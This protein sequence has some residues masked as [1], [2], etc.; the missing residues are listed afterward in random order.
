MNISGLRSTI[1]ITALAANAFAV[2]WATLTQDIV[3]QGLSTEKEANPLIEKAQTAG[4]TTEQMADL[5]EP[6]RKAGQ[7]HLPTRPLLDKLEEGLIK[8]VKP[9]SL[10]QAISTRYD[11][12]VQASQLTQIIQPP[13]DKVLYSVT[14]ALE[15]GVPEPVLQSVITESKGQNSGQIQAVVE[16]GETMYLNGLDATS[17]Q[18]LMT[19][20]LQR[21]LRRSEILRTT[22]YACQQHRAG[23]QG[24]AIRQSLWGQN[25]CDG[26]GQRQRARDGSGGGAGGEVGKEETARKRVSMNRGQARDNPINKVVTV[27]R[28]ETEDKAAREDRDN[29][30]LHPCADFPDTGF[31]DGLRTRPDS[32]DS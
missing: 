27:D 11:C 1:F 8:Q 30:P 25:A 15:S 6:V 2:D 12:L 20:C 4:Y 13:S 9:E 32:D 21:R 19:D 5:L 14:R 28:A 17:V 26:T 10:H 31:R 29:A 24:Q 22:R 18:T 16:A 7:Q 23:M 3:Q